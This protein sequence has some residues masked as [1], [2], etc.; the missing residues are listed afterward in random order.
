QREHGFRVRPGLVT[1]SRQKRNQP[2]PD[3][4]SG[5]LPRPSKAIDVQNALV[6]LRDDREPGL[7]VAAQDGVLRLGVWINWPDGFEFF[8]QGVLLPENTGI[9]RPDNSF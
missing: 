1:A 4:P 7:P 2:R 6:V 8:D 5:V 9:G 3:L